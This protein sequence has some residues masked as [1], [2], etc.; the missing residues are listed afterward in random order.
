LSL[1]KEIKNLEPAKVL[2]ARIRIPD[3]KKMM[4]VVRASVKNQLGLIG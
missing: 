2:E 4:I 3:Y 1:F